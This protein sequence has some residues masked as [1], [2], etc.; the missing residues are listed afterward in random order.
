[1]FNPKHFALKDSFKDLTYKEIFEKA[2][3][4]CSQQNQCKSISTNWHVKDNKYSVCLKS[5]LK[6][7]LTFKFLI[8]SIMPY[9]CNGKSMPF[10][11]KL[12]Q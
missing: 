2:K 10:F 7:Y 1:M 3:L 11:N 8:M 9:V 5:H 6:G 12:F 4:T